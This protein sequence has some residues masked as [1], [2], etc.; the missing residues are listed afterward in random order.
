MT[1][2]PEEALQ[3]LRYLGLTQMHV[4]RQTGHTPQE[5]SQWVHGRASAPKP[6][7][8]WL[9]Q[10]ATILRQR[11]E[12][13]YLQSR[14]R[15]NLDHAQMRG[16]TPLRDPDYD[17]FNLRERSPRGQRIERRLTVTTRRVAQ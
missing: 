1:G 13:E 16:I 5:V 6:V 3:N 15:G 11:I 17:Q 10:Y 8:A 14:L 9:G 7:L 4:A 2:R 12:I